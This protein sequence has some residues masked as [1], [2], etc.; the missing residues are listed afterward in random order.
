M[1]ITS[2]LS[3]KL[4]KKHFWTGSPGTFGQ[5]FVV[6]TVYLAYFIPSIFKVE[7]GIMPKL[8]M[9]ARQTD[10]TAVRLS[11]A[12]HQNGRRITSFMTSPTSMKQLYLLMVKGRQTSCIRI[13]KAWAHLISSMVSAL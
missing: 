6:A 7:R 11:T 5:I 12:V 3:A 10:D 9:R 13:R 2:I 1:Y 8:V 4:R